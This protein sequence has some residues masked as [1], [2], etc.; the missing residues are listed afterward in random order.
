MQ[1]QFVNLSLFDKEISDIR[2]NAAYATITQFVASCGDT[3]DLND[4]CGNEE[5]SI[6][7][8]LHFGLHI[9]LTMRRSRRMCWTIN[10]VHIS[11]FIHRMSLYMQ[12]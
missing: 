6:A 2:A 7:I 12:R 5:H 10:R 3:L 8:T 4:S 9:C 1:L 11:K